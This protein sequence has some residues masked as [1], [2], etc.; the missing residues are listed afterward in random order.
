MDKLLLLILKD[1]VVPELASFIHD[2]FNKT[3]ELP[4]QAELQE[5]VNSLSGKI[6]MKGEAFIKLLESK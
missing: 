4:T 2:H 3:G 5:R 6:V 1:V